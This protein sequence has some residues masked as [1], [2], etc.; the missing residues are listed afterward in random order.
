MAN[1]ESKIEIKNIS[2]EYNYNDTNTDAVLFNINDS[3]IQFLEWL[4]QDH[5]IETRD[6][7]LKTNQ[8]DEIKELRITVA[9]VHDALKEAFIDYCAK[10]A[11]VIFENN[12]STIK[13]W[14]RFTCKF[15]DLAYQLYLDRYN[16]TLEIHISA[17]A[18]ERRETDMYKQISWSCNKSE[19]KESPQII[20]ASLKA[21]TDYLVT[22]LKSDIRSA[23]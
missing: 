12:L 17:C 15:D 5:E 13:Q 7:H 3:E 14:I 6:S 10:L 4:D 19:D 16:Y 1:Q 23:L 18:T 21:S 8:S 11:D 2:I 20:Y 9:E 22:T